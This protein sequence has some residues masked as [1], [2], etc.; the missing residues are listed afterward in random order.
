MHLAPSQVDGSDVYLII[1]PQNIVGASIF[2]DLRD[3]REAAG[4]APIVLINPNLTDRPSSGGVMSGALSG[5]TETI[6][7]F[8]RQ[9]PPPHPHRTPPAVHVTHPSPT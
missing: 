2:E 1:A 9:S 5:P 8:P 3:M 7:A 6:S 4:K